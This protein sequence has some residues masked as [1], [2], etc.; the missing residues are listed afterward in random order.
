[1]SEYD[2]ASD[3]WFHL[4]KADQLTVNHEKFKEVNE[5]ICKCMDIVESIQHDIEASGN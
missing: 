2:R 5:L 1:M 4:S 3:T